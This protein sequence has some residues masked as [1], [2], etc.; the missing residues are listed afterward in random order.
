VATTTGPVNRSAAGPGLE[1]VPWPD[2][3]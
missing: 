2:T 1:D 3:P